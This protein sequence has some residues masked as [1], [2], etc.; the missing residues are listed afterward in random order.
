MFSKIKYEVM[1]ALCSLGM[2]QSQWGLSGGGR[3]GILLRKKI[4]FRTQEG[5]QQ[6]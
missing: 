5:L 6:L 3:E 4:Q 2:L 1:E